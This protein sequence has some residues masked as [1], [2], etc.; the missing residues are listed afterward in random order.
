[1]TAFFIVTAIAGTIVLNV[2]F[3]RKIVRKDF[4]VFT[5]VANVVVAVLLSV[6]FIAASFAD[7]YLKVF[8]DEQTARLEFTVN[9]IYPG[10]FE[11]SFST[12]EAKEMLESSLETFESPDSVIETVTV[13]LVKM[14]FDKYF[15]LAIS[16]IN[17]LEQTEGTISLKDAISSL[18]TLLLERNAALFKLIRL[19]L[20]AVY[21]IFFVASLLASNYLKNG[22]H[23]ENKSI[24]FGEQ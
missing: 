19:T 20:I 22:G 11:K 9:K 17:A 14:R 10:A 21:F 3:A 7:K 12:T 1:M 16:A 2:L 18:K 23:K 13:N 5:E 15:S 6:L 4:R 8:L 24:V